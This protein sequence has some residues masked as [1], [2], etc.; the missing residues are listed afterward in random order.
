[1]TAGRQVQR[2]EETKRN[3][4]AAAGALFSEKGFDAVTM[5]EIARKAGCSH[6]AIYIYFKDK[7]ALLHQLSMPPLLRLQEEFRRILQASDRPPEHNLQE[8][9]LAFIRFCLTNRNMRDVFFNVN[10]VRVDEAQPKLE[11]NKARNELFGM[12]T[13]ALRDCLGIDRNDERLL[14]YS[15]I[16]YYTLYGIVGTYA[17]SP[18]SAEQ[19]LARLAPTFREAFEALLIGFTYKIREGADGK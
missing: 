5:R 8:I 16:T 15:R 3:I 7:E 11:L 4:L 17:H 1:M 6:T 18:E 12:L 19:L 13:E 2:S 14:A 10:A 9:C